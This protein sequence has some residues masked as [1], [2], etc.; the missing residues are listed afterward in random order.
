MSEELT[1][2]KFVSIQ[3]KRLDTFEKRFSNGIRNDNWP[4]T[5]E[6][7]DWVEQ[8]F[9]YFEELIDKLR[10]EQENNETDN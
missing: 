10:S 9:A 8:E 6:Y 4:D 1:L 5:L 3:K 7:Q 2:R